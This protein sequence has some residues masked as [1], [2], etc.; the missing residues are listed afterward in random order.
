MAHAG[1]KTIREREL[2]VK[3]DDNQNDH[4]AWECPLQI[5]TDTRTAALGFLNNHSR[6]AV[7]MEFKDFV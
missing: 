6:N 4:D 1:V 7:K 5:F 2:V 3:M